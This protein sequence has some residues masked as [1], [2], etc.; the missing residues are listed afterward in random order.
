MELA[1]LAVTG[2][3]ALQSE[4]QSCL[5]QIESCE[6]VTVA[7][8][9]EALELAMGSDFTAVLIDAG[10]N[11][12]PLVRFAHELVTEH[13]NI[14]LLVIPPEN[15]LHHPVLKGLVFTSMLLR[16]LDVSALR[17]GLGLDTPE[18]EE[19]LVE[20]EDVQQ[21]LQSPPVP[22]MEDEPAVNE[23]AII[24]DWLG[25]I[26]TGFEEQELDEPLPSNPDIDEVTQAWERE[27]EQL[28]TTPPPLPRA[29]L[30]VAPVDELPTPGMESTSLFDFS[31]TAVTTKLDPNM[32]ELTLLDAAG[33]AESK[34]G[35]RETGVFPTMA[36]D[37]GQVNSPVSA[38]ETLPLT[39]ESY[40]DVDFS[41]EQGPGTTP[42]GILGVRFKYTV[43]LIPGMPHHFLAQELSGR[44][45]F[46]L[47]QIHLTQGWK[48]TGISI[49]PTHLLWQ[50]NL[51]ANISPLDAVAQIRRR[52]STHIFTNFPQL[53]AENMSND[54]W[55]PGYLILSGDT[56][57]TPPTIRE[58]IQRTRQ[59]N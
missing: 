4:I 58:F 7:T 16:P 23:E 57:P 12:I 2:D 32:V 22:E 52:T 38:G 10:E 31:H 30:D 21:T 24:P 48:I 59:S 14:R 40:L 43:V 29:E 37:T 26:D 42:L 46:I 11:D 33:D 55:A 17:V 5:E 13:G 20:L 25:D 34:L 6:L 36:E 54:F 19:N 44:L 39:G 35:N 3:P 8:K 41:P 56:P 49:R 18:F 50:F 45:G 47:P 28:L 53:A 15:N 27:E 9:T 51:P 1:I